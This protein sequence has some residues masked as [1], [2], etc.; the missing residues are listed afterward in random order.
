MPESVK[1]MDYK[2]KNNSPD[3]W[4]I[5][6]LVWVKAEDEPDSSFLKEMT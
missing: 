4:R 1:K 6:S 3:I 5:Y 2:P